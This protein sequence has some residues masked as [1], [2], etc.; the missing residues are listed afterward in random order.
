[1]FGLSVTARDLDEAVDRS[2][3][4]STLH[5]IWIRM[6]KP[7]QVT[8]C[9]YHSIQV[10]CTHTEYFLTGQVQISIL[11]KTA[12]NSFNGNYCETKIATTLT[13]H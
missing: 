10:L 12:R 11:V 7:R 4:N 8:T 1:M 13:V 5:T 6:L 2:D 3:D 9:S